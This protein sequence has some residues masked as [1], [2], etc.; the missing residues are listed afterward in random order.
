LLPG[1]LIGLGHLVVSGRLPGTLAGTLAPQA[2]FL[3][4]LAALLLLGKGEFAKPGTQTS[5]GSSGT[6]LDFPE[7]Q[8]FLKP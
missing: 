8:P 4:V 3:I 2:P 1:K 7:R 6:R 5:T